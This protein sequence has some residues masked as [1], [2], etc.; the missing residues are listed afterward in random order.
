MFGNAWM[1]SKVRFAFDVVFGW[2]CGTGA[3][4][5]IVIAL[6]EI[7]RH[8]PFAFNYFLYL[9]VCAVAGVGICAATIALA[10]AGRLGQVAALV[11]GAS[12]G[13]PVAPAV[14]WWIIIHV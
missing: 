4:M 8:E 3:F 2:L 10:R 14:V 1:T 5:L 13:A 11:A 6:G 9:I 7:L 12:V